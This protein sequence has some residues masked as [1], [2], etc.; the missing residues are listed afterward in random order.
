MYLC[1]A[2]DKTRFLLCLAFIVIGAMERISNL[3]FTKGLNLKITIIYVKFVNIKI[4]YGTCIKER[5][6]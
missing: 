5:R 3:V 6:D 1:A 4:L 2:G